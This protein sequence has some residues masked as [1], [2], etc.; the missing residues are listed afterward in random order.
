M[1]NS[2]KNHTIIK[3]T[4]KK[5]EN[6]FKGKFIEFHLSETNRSFIHSIFLLSYFAVVVVIVR[7]LISFIYFQMQLQ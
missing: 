5:E 6:S 3:T 4:A 7:T 2:K 1:R